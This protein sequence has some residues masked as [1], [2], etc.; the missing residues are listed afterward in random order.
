MSNSHDSAIQIHRH[1]SATDE[2]VYGGALILRTVSPLT[3]RT[4]DSL[5]ESKFLYF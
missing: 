3:Y 2:K 5:Q 4:P 1:T